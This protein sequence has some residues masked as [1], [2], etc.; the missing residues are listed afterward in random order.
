MAD[1]YEY[2]THIAF[3]LRTR[4]RFT[5]SQINHTTLIKDIFTTLFNYHDNLVV[6]QGCRISIRFILHQPLAQ[7]L[8]NVRR[9]QLTIAKLYTPSQK[10]FFRYYFVQLV[11]FKYSD[12]VLLCFVLMGAFSFISKKIVCNHKFSETK[13]LNI[14][15]VIHMYQQKIIVYK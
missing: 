12:F 4:C 9:T 6:N 11:Y 5:D 7:L 15:I 1:Q 2:L 14:S 8:E 3:I 13:I 10:Y